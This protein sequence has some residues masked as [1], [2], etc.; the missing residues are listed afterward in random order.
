M[1]ELMDSGH[2]SAASV[3]SLLEVLIA[4]IDERDHERIAKRQQELE[5]LYAEQ[6][7]FFE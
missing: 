5:I 3:I 1:D 4:G 2:H 7:R 6:E